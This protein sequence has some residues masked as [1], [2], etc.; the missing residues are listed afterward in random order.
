MP[1]DSKRQL[2]FAIFTLM[3]VVAVDILGMML[4]VPIIDTFSQSLGASKAMIGTQFTVYSASSILASLV[5]GR[6]SDYYGRRFIFMASSIGGAVAAIAC[7]FITTFDEFLITSAFSG[8]FVGTVGTAYAYVGDLVHDEAR[9]SRYIS[10]ITASLSCCLVLGPLIGGSV[11]T[12][13]LRAPFIISAGIA[14]I[15]LL[16]VIFC[17]KNPQDLQAWKDNRIVTN[18]LQSDATTKTSNVDSLIYPEHSSSSM[19]M[20]GAVSMKMVSALDD[21]EEDENDDVNVHLLE[22]GKEYRYPSQFANKPLPS[23]SMTNNTPVSS[24]NYSNAADIV[25]ALHP[26]SAARQAST[27]NVTTSASASATVQ[28]T[29]YVGGNQNTTS[30][31]N[32]NNNIQ[33]HSI[34]NNNSNI[35]SSISNQNNPYFNHS[36]NHNSNLHAASLVTVIVTED[37]EQEHFLTDTRET[38]KNQKSYYQRFLNAWYPSQSSISSSSSNRQSNTRITIENT[39][40]TTTTPNASSAAAVMS[41]VTGTTDNRPVQSSSISSTTTTNTIGS[42][43]H[44]PLSPWMDYRAV[45]IGGLGTLFNTVT[46]L[47]LI[48]LVPLL[49]QEDQFGIVSPDSNGDGQTDDSLT[50]HDIKTISFMMGVYLGCYG[51]VQVICMIFVFPRCV[52]YF[53]LLWT[54]AIG[55]FIY[56]TVYCLIPFVHTTTGFYMIFMGMAIGNSLCRPSFPSYLGKIANKERRAEYM[57]VSATF[58]NIALMIAGQMTLLYTYTRIGAIFICGGA[59]IVNGLIFVLFAVTHT[60]NPSHDMGEKDES[61]SLDSRQVQPD[62]AIRR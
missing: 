31:N 2:Q 23:H 41:A 60:D 45:M 1:W 18:P 52:N 3:V 4:L 34:G 40:A 62:T 27:S 25:H 56:G 17:L 7:V 51:T 36:F 58:G 38:K 47:G 12:L 26:N 43:T 21:D 10:Y 29:V 57:T 11:A 44:K 39:T 20:H 6:I 55:C 48:A 16:L 28:P 50:N 33:S 54:G 13:Y 53:G 8:L 19:D 61:L 30:Y 49:L 14:I 37:D 9:R 59:S 46:Y 22:E 35:S 42:T 5:I 24:V 32:N 15:E